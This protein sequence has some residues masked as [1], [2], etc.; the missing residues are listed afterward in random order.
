M[1]KH[2]FPITPSIPSSLKIYYYRFLCGK[3]KWRYNESYSRFSNKI[4]PIY[5]LR[6]NDF[7][8]YF[9]GDLV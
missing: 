6:F 4:Y 1:K 5:L 9:G 8:T 3:N 2:D 7:N